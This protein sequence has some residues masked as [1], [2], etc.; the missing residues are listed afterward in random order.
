M[1]ERLEAEVANRKDKETPEIATPRIPLSGF[2]EL[3]R[4]RHGMMLANKNDVYIGRSLREYGEFSE[5]EVDLF[6]QIVRPGSVVVESGS[7]VGAH[8]I[9]LARL[10]GNKGIVFAFEPQRVVFQTLC[11]NVALNSLSNVECRHAALGDKSGTIAVPALDYSRENNFGG[12]GLGGYKHGEPVLVVTIDSLELPRCDFIKVDVE[13]MEIQVLQGA[14]RTIEK[15][16]PV[17]YVENDREAQSA[18]LITLIHS[19]GYKLYWHTPRMFNPA[20]YFQ[21]TKD[22]FG[23]IVSVNMLCLPESV[24]ANVEGFRPITSPDSNWRDP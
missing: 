1:A 13:G 6:R 18:E 5:G 20:N 11:A 16:Q 24:R 14:R 22:L 4:G 9:P 12:L 23:G 7:N 2:N 15:Y 19:M 17:L 3:I 21:N 8:T 10:V